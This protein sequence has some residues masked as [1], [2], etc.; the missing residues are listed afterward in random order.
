MDRCM[1]MQVSPVL[2]ELQHHAVGVAAVAHGH[3]AALPVLYKMMRNG[4]SGL[5]SGISQLSLAQ[6]RVL[7]A[8]KRQMHMGVHEHRQDGGL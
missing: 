4:L 3:N 5:F 2:C 1:L 6:M 8:G 7:I